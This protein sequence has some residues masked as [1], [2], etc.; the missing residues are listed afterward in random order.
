M[1]LETPIRGLPYAAIDFESTGLPGP[2]AHVVE[3]AVVHGTLGDDT[4]PC[5]VLSE[6]VRPPIPIPTEASRIHGISDADVAGAPPWAEVWPRVEAAIRGRLLVA[7]NAPAD[8]AFLAAELARMSLPAPEP[9]LC[10]LVVRKATKLRG[11]PGRLTEVAE[12][13]GIVLDAHGAAG[14]ALALALVLRPLLRFAVEAGVLPRTRTIGDLLA[15][16]RE[17]ALEQEREWASY[18]RRQGDATPP[19]SPW[20]RVFGE[21]APT[22]AP[23]MRTAR[24][25]CGAAVQ[26]TI[27]QNGAVRRVQPGTTED[28]TCKE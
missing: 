2:D 25:T 9:W 4:S 6:R 23:P 15:W 19:D 8:R 21:P 20:H 14:D 5:L 11:R 12:E 22:W 26:M 1:T 16:Q 27:G 17:T 3:V 7:Y 18:R 28:H 24:C 10:A 13:Y